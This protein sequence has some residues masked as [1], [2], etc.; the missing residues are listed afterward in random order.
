V[1]FNVSD[2]ATERLLKSFAYLLEDATDEEGYNEKLFWMALAAAQMETGRLVPHVRD[3]ALEVIDSGG[4]VAHWLENGDAQSA[5][6]REW[7]L[8]RLAEKLRGRQPKPKR[9]RRPPTLSVPFEVGDVV[10]VRDEDGDEA[11]VV[12]VGRQK[13]PGP[14]E[15]NPIVAP[16]LWTCGAIPDREEMARLP[17]VADAMAPEP[18]LPLLIGVHTHSKREVFGPELGVVVAKGVARDVDADPRRVNHYTNWRVVPGRFGRRSR[19]RAFA[20]RGRRAFRVRRRKARCPWSSQAI[21]D[22]TEWRRT[23][24]ET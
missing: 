22:S 10:H 17:I 2:E 7:V 20:R 11:L 23:A 14:D 24:A 18:L 21:Q 6:Q 8:Q 13:G 9:I 1:Q 3:R 12:V 15:R 19:C 16:L 4:D 5:K